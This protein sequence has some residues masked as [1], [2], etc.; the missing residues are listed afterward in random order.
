MLYKTSDPESGPWTAERPWTLLLKKTQ[1]KPNQPANQP[2][3]K[4]PLN[5]CPCKTK[6]K[7]KEKKAFH[8]TPDKKL[9]S[10]IKSN[11]TIRQGCS[12]T[13]QL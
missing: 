11:I 7:N 13:I 3:K 4:T 10:T 8:L 5:A 12:Y 9:L 1:S 2:I 6:Q